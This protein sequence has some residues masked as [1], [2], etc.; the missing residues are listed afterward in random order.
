MVEELQVIAGVAAILG[1]FHVR[2]YVLKYRHHSW[3][4]FLWVECLQMKA[5]C[6]SP[7]CPESHRG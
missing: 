7:D 4:S 2:F 1:R 5:I 6:L 3:K